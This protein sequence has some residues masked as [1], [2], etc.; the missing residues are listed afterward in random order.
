MSEDSSLMHLNRR[1]FLSG[2]AAGGAAS[3][4]GAM[5]SEAE[6]QGA[7]ISSRPGQRYV[8]IADTDEQRIADLVSAN[9]VC[10]DLGIVDGMGHVTARS[11]KDPTHYFMAQSIAPGLVTKDDIIE[12]DQDSK[13]I[14]AGMRPYHGER[15]IHGEIYRARPDVQGIVHCHTSVVVSFGLSG[16]PGVA[17]RPVF[18]M[19]GFLPA[20]VPVF[21]IRNAPDNGGYHGMEVLN[22]PLGVELAK[23]LGN[24]SVVLMR[25]HGMT[26]VG[27]SVIQAVSRANYTV[28][29]AQIQLEAMRLGPVVYLNPSVESL[30]TGQARAG[31]PGAREQ[32]DRNWPLWKARADANSAGYIAAY[33]K[34]RQA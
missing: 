10:S 9:H 22:H 3:V 34:S 16:V 29:N 5:P 23:T 32:G 33:N 11:I 1:N 8:K 4:L 7:S 28:I 2:I 30:G 21:E 20:V 6:E 24:S 12:F 14:D 13:P 18:H 17:L 31:E 15:F 27:S 25:G 19:A 26:V